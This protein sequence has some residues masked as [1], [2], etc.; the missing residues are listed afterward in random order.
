M[1]AVAA[2]VPRRWS[3]LLAFGA[4]ALLVWAIAW[5][6][7][8]HLQ[9][10]LPG[11]PSGDTGVYIWNFWVF[12]YELLVAHGTPLWTSRILQPGPPID[13]ALHNYTI[14]QDGVGLALT[15]L[16]GLVG[17]FN[18]TLL[19]MQALAGFGVFLL[20]RRYT[21]RDSIAWLAGALFACSPTIITRSLAH[22]SLVAAGPLALFLLFVLRAA[23]RRTLADALLAGV[24]AAWAAIC[25]AYYGIYCVPL[26]IC[27]GLVNVLKWESR[28]ERSRR[29]AA[30]TLVTG[31]MIVPIAII[32]FIL[33]T[34]GGRINLF[35]VSIRMRTLYT[36]MLALTALAIVRVLLAILGRGRW[37]LR[38]PIDR[39]RLVQLGAG[40]LAC[41]LLLAPLVNTARIRVQ[42]GGTLQE[43]VMWRSSPPGVD[44]LAFLVP[45]PNHPLAPPAF[46]D[47]LTPRP[48]MYP[49]NVASIPYVAI[50]VIALALVHR[51]RPTL[52][53]TLAVVFGLLALGPFITIGHVNTHVPGPWALL[54]YLPIIGS[55]RT[56]GRFAIPMLIAIAVL[57]A[58]ALQRIAA[59]PRTVAIV[60]IAIACELLPVPRVT[61][62]ASVPPLYST[63]AADPDDVSVLELPFGIWDGRSRVGFANVA[64][65]Y[66]QTTHGK[67]LIGGY[68][69]R[70]PRAR[71]RAHLQFPTLR[72]L[73]QLSEAQAAIAPNLSEAAREDAP[74]FAQ[75][76]RLRY[77]VIDTRIASRELRR[78]AIDLLKLQLV[79][80]DGMLELYR[81]GSDPN[82]TNS[83]NR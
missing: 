64:T 60:A 11:D 72:L 59:R 79:Q 69:S 76:A 49:E 80:T 52:L 16:V 8:I 20:A 17:A 66:Y 78:T 34:G 23:D 12:R 74:Y 38:H 63:I 48:D 21:T 75:Q 36:P 56:P 35:G 24:C 73:A 41:G 82:F 53:V 28:A 1:I 25:D 29:S 46:R 33:V 31:L 39:F 70:V 71:V 10:R 7:S 3:T 15:P 57:F 45:N 47:F 50:V 43:P 5:P 22:Q 67:R 77:V 42:R 2:P 51:P 62:N 19:L 44:L 61:G 14:F 37:H 55:A 81:T 6:L 32:I 18:I 9:S 4:Y 40:A 13:L 68:L 30:G 54:R 27:V 83:V 26:L 65:Q 58:W